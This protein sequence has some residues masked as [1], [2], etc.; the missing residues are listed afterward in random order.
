MQPFAALQHSV[1]PSGDVLVHSPG[2]GNA[3]K[4]HENLYHA[5]PSPNPFTWR[6]NLLRS[7][8]ALSRPTRTIF[9]PS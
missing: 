1:S 3:I 9:R 2:F 5:M 6:K 7:T 8:N 4:R